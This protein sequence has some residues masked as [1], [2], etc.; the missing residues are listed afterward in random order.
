[1]MAAVHDFGRRLE[2]TSSSGERSALPSPVV[3]SLTYRRVPSAM[4]ALPRRR[5]ALPPLATWAYRDVRAPTTSA[6][7]PSRSVSGTSPTSRLPSRPAPAKAQ[8]LAEALPRLVTDHSER[9]SLI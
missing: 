1:M 4:V 9:S 2:T 6:S 7:R 8:A 5:P 3:Y